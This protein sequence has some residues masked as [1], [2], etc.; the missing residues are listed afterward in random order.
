MS[1]E[2]ARINQFQI[3]TLFIYTLT[4]CL[5]HLETAVTWFHRFLP[6]WNQLDITMELLSDGVGCLEIR[7][8]FIL[9]R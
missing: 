5:L 9:H 6:D 2:K 1:L 4:S 3:L 7:D 8:G